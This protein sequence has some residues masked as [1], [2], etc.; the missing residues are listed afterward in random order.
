[1]NE[2]ANED[3]KEK[4]INRIGWFASIMA[5]LMFVSYV[6]QIRLNLA[7]Q[8]RLSSSSLCYHHQL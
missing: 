8:K 4:W 2:W 6:D 3:K 7:G 5:L 1:M